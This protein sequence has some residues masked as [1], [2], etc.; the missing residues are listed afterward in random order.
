MNPSWTEMA[1]KD[2]IGC[3]NPFDCPRMCVPRCRLCYE[4]DGDMTADEL[5]KVA[6]SDEPRRTYLEVL[7][8]RK[9]KA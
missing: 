9:T 7:T 1:V 3:G 6:R 2:C 5:E 8:A 4:K